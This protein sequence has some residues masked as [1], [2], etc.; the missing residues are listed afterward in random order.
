MT[1]LELAL[2]TGGI[3]VLVNVVGWILT[4]IKLSKDQA[5]RFAKQAERF[6]VLETQM[7]QVVS[8]CAKF[9]SFEVSIAGLKERVTVLEYA[10]T[11]NGR[12]KSKQK[13]ESDRSKS[14]VE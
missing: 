1:P 13:K 2:I 4:A 10:V 14:Q 5:S 7:A 9:D 12:R 8:T 6:A 3:L 11:H